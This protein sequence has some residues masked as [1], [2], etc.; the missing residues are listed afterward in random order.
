LG[1]GRL[2]VMVG[3]HGCIVGRDTEIACLATSNKAPLLTPFVR[4]TS[5]A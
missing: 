2:G 3:D 4:L 1:Q 5:N